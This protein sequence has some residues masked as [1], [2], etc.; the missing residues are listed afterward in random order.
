MIKDSDFDLINECF[1]DIIV[2]LFGKV[3]IIGKVLHIGRLFMKKCN[4]LMIKTLVASTILSLSLISLSG[5]NKSNSADEVD[6]QT[7]SNVISHYN[8]KIGEE[9]LS[10]YKD[11]VTTMS[12]NKSFSEMGLK[13]EYND[14]ELLFPFN[15]NILVNDGWQLSNRTYSSDI[16]KLNDY[17]DAAIY[18]SNKYGNSELVLSGYKISGQSGVAGRQDILSEYGAYAMS[19]WYDVNSEICPNLKICGVDVFNANESELINVLNISNTIRSSNYTIMN[20]TTYSYV[21]DFGSYLVELKVACSNGTVTQCSFTTTVASA[22][23]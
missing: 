21:Y 18:T 11:I 5:C 7:V 12:S 4:K 22:T 2:V 1:C 20:V 9:S 13:V 23:L 16:N 8:V 6:K 19:L 14:N 3:G 10:E 15:V 17:T